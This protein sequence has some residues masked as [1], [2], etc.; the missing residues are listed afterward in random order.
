MKRVLFVC[1]KARRRSTT[2]AQVFASS[3]GIETDAAGLSADADVPLD[4]EQLDWATD[5]AVMEK[6]QLGR[7]RKG[8]AR[9]LKGKRI[10]F[11]D[12]PD[13]YDFMDPRLVALLE[14]RF[15]RV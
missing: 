10:V 8:F 11:L 9:H 12:I 14:R 7:L 4:T 13:D 5:I 3:F 1:G 6:R 15:S 2:A